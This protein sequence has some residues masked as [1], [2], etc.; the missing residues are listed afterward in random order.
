MMKKILTLILATSL[1]SL[2][3]SAQLPSWL[4][5][6]GLIAWYPFHAN[7]N[8]G[9]GN[10]NNGTTSNVVLTTDRFGTANDAYLFNGTT[11]YIEAPNSTSLQSPTK[12]ITMSAWINPV[13]LSLV[14]YTA[15]GPI[16]CKSSTNASAA[17][18]AMT[19][20]TSGASLDVYTNVYATITTAAYTF[21]FNKWYMVTTVLDSSKAYFYV[22]GSLIK[23][24]T[25]TTNITQDTRSLRIG[26]DTPVGTE[27]FNGKIDD[28]AI[29]NRALDSNEVKQ[30]YL[31][32]YTPTAALISSLGSTTFCQGDEVTLV[33]SAAYSLF[34]WKKGNSN[35][36][37]A[38][39]NNYTANNTGSYKCVVTNGCGTVT[40][41]VISVVRDTL[42]S[43][44]IS[45]GGA[46][47]FCLGGSVT[48][49]T[50]NPGAG[51]TYQWFRNNISIGGATTLTY[52][53][54]NAGT[55]K[56]A[57]TKTSNGCVRHSGTKKVVVTTC[58]NIV[59]QAAQD[60]TQNNINVYPN[61][62]SNSFTFELNEDLNGMATISLLNTLGQEVFTTKNEIENGQPI[63]NIY[64]NDKMKAGIYLLRINVGDKMF[65]SKVIIS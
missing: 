58:K 3:C 24:N 21:T 16:I 63:D 53:A 50:T 25:F 5:S 45:A 64:I 19:L 61:P 22:N 38:T 46:L 31:A 10:N 56:V 41:N 11:S 60:L 34:Q 48:L 65:V 42:A 36:A 2:N 59:G 7:A 6:N 8:D 37:G 39:K 55:Y 13:G 4:P 28:L 9:S 54:Y 32:C 35:I 57:I 20:N 18:Y 62:V 23:T 1:C 47:S 51:Y 49:S 12:R 44:S 14:G 33:D 43:V 17:M 27:T 15:M 29:W 40:S 26:S 52:T 30:L